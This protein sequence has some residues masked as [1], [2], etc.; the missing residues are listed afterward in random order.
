MAVTL[1][2]ARGAVAG[3]E[4]AVVEWRGKVAASERAASERRTYGP[5]TVVDA[6]ARWNEVAA[7]VAQLDSEAMVARGA[8]AAAR[9][10]LVEAR[11]DALLAAAVE[12]DRAADEAER[13][14]GRHAEKVE[15]AMRT[16]VVLEGV[17]YEPAPMVNRFTGQVTRILPSTNSQRLL[18][19]MT[20]GRL[21]AAVLR[22]AA[23][24]G[25]S[26]ASPREVSAP[27]F[28]LQGRQDFPEVLTEF[29]PLDAEPVRRRRSLA[30]RV[31]DNVVCTTAAGHP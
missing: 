10:R 27:D 16:L 26:P 14:Y 29:L 12:E 23:E 22:F 30:D 17:E 7:E 21:R 2:A 11:R 5:A 18:G 25:K 3:A 19:R 15:A 1:E 6:P 4:A 9:E 31:A 20:Q 13:S 24:H 28:P 8:L